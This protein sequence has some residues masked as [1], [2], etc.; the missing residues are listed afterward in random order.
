MVARARYQQGFSLIELMVTIAI[1]GILATTGIALTSKWS[2]QVELDKAVMSLNSGMA[3]AKS[4]ALRNEFS[5]GVSDSASQI[6]FGSHTLSVHVATASAPASCTTTTVFQYPLGQSVS[7]KNSDSTD[8][9]C[10]S[11]NHLGVVSSTGSCT[12]T[13]SLTVNNGSLNESVDLS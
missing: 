8:F 5:K 11:F 2:Q 4:T 9:S 10:F 3:L 6:C 7:I 13:L 1:L 12:T